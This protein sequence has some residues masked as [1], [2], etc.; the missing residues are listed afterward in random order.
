[1]ADPPSDMFVKKAQFT[2][3]VYRDVYPTVYR[4]YFFG[5]Y[6]ELLFTLAGRNSQ[7]PVPP[8]P[9]KHVANWL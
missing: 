1:M 8:P 4:T 6:H 3:T 5:P 7:L 9:K 2:K